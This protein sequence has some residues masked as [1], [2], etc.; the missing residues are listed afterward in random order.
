MRQPGQIQLAVWMILL[1]MIG[2][3]ACGDDGDIRNGARD[4]VYPDPEW[5][6]EAPEAHDLDSIRLEEAAELAEE[7]ASNCL[8]VTR[9]GVIVGEWYWNDWGPTSEQHVFSVTKSLTS[10]LVGIAQERGELDITDKASEYI[11]EWVGTASEDVTIQ[12][13]ISNDSGRHWDLIT[14]YLRMAILGEDKTDIA[15]GLGQQYLP[16]TVWNY[17]NSAIQTLEPVLNLATGMDVADYADEVL[18]GPLGMASS[19]G[20]DTAGNPLTFAGAE[21]SCRDLARFGTLYL[22]GGRWSGGRQIVPE[23]W[24]DESVRPSTPLNAAYGYMWWLNRDGHWVESLH[25]E[26]DGKPLRGLP[27]NVFRASGFFNQIVFVDPGT[28][29]VFTR[30]GW[31]TGIEDASSSGLVEG[32]AKGIRAARLD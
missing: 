12:N 7:H 23:D 6:V 2:F 15:V 20:R 22:R 5:T 9:D 18:F 28:G 1:S 24:V 32:L 8:V 25:Q 17:N 4:F 19:Y 29:I 10:A 21:C 31:V 30:I 27:E 3:S 26:G 11:S 14:D 13:L 16:G